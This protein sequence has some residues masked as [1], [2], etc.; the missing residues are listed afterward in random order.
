MSHTKI[1]VPTVSQGGKAGRGKASAGGLVGRAFHTTL[2]KT[3]GTGT[4]WQGEVIAD[5]G[6]GYY[7]A[8]LFE[9]FMG[10]A[11]TQHVFHIGEFAKTHPGEHH[12]VFRFFETVMQMN[13]YYEAHRHSEMKPEEETDPFE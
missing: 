13:D 11:S 4:R 1:G 8:Q 10:S 7:L 2:P 12:K 5:L 6:D 9:W 3:N